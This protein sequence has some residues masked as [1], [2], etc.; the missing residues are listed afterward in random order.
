MCCAPQR[1]AVP[2]LLQ[3]P[4]LSADNALNSRH[5]FVDVNTSRDVLQPQINAD[6]AISGIR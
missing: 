4:H 2:L 3:R 6:F 1:R 5:Q